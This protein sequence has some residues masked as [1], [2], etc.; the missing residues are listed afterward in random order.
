MS[1]P[2]TLFRGFLLGRQVDPLL[3]SIS[4]SSAVLFL[5]AGIVVFRKT[6]SY[7]ADLA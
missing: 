3:C 6:E 7:F 5:I 1:G 2:I 4:C